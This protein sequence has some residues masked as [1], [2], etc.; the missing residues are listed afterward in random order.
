MTKRVLLATAALVAFFAG[1]PAMAHHSANAEFDT[2]KEF[3]ITGVLTKM[4]I[5]NQH[6][7][8]YVDVKE[9]D[10]KVTSWKLETNSPQGLIAKGLKVKTDIK[11]GDTYTYRIAPAWKD[12]SDAKLGWMKAIT[13]NGKEFVVVEL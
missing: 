11:V 7:W 9:A 13:I 8:L 1:S 10:G 3:K 12:P 4:E 2:T 5:V 6:S